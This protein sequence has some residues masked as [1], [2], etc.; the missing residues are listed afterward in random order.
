MKRRYRNTGPDRET[1]MAVL[2][3]DHFRCVRCGAPAQGERGVAWSLQHRKKRSAGVDNRP[4]NLIVLRGSGTT[5]CHGWVEAH[6]TL[7][8]SEGGWSVSRYV[9]PA[10]VA[11]L[12]DHG[13]RW[14]LLDLEGHYL[15]A[16][17]VPA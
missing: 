4:C 6:P 8:A 10:E 16:E 17:G 14:V 7:A 12:V 5:F 1:V 11:V 13:S 3:R 2:A 9:D 15:D